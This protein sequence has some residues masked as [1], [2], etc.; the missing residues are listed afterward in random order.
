VSEWQYVDAEGKPYTV[1]ATA[2]VAGTQLRC[3]CFAAYEEVSY[4]NVDGHP[5]VECHRCGGTWF[6]LGDRLF[7]LDLGEFGLPVVE[8]IIP[9]SDPIGPMTREYRI[10]WKP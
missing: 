4:H 7:R 5:L 3:G 2:T 9:D 6:I 1:T 10:E 8:F